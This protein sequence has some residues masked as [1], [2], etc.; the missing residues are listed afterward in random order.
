MLA[1]SSILAALNARHSS[2]KGQKVELS[3]Y[4]TSL[5]MLINVA[6][7]YLIAGRNGGRFGNGGAVTYRGALTFET[8]SPALGSLN[9]IAG[10]FEFDVD[11][12]GNTQTKIWEW[13]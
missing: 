10:A 2:G 1:C 11:A 3:L 13:K 4:E 8:I 7:N 5:A 6:S 12:A 9:G